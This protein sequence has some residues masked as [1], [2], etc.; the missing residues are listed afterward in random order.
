MAAP[1]H[2]TIDGK[3]G[4]RMTAKDDLRSVTA[5]N[6]RIFHLLCQKFAKIAKLSRPLASDG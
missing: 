6:C 1:L 3:D 4:E 2:D 5:G